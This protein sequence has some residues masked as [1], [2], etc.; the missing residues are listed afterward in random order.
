[1]DIKPERDEG[2]FERREDAF[3]DWVGS[4]QKAV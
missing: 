1:M 4:L 3:R 2:A